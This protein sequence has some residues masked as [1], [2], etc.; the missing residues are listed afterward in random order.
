[1]ETWVVLFRG[2][3]VGGKHQLPMKALSTHL[4]AMGLERVRTYIQSGNVVVDDPQ[5]RSGAELAEAIRALVAEKFGF[6]P[7]VWTLSR[8]EW[9]Q[10]VAANPYASEAAA[11]G[12]S[13]HAY[14]L[15]A[16]PTAPDWP[17]LQAVQSPTER[18]HLGGRVFYLHAPDGIGRSTLA[19]RVEKALGVAATA[20][21]WNTV[22]ELQRMV[23]G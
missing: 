15:E 13:V 9:A 14:F 8:P 3:N 20:R 10:A 17:K 2:I 19:E 23:E 7:K 4:T 21:N 11:E 16:E 18:T 6:A 12:K 1:M 5:G 22:A